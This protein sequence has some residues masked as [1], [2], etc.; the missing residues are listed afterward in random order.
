[1][2]PSRL[3]SRCGFTAVSRLLWFV[4]LPLS[5]LNS[6]REGIIFAFAYHQFSAPSL[7]LD[8]YSVLSKYFC[9]INAWMKI[10]GKKITWFGKIKIFSPREEKVILIFSLPDNFM[11][12]LSNRLYFFNKQRFTFIPWTG[13]KVCN[14]GIQAELTSQNMQTESEKFSHYFWEKENEQYLFRNLL[15]WWSANSSRLNPSNMW[16]RTYLYGSFV[17]EE[18]RNKQEMVVI[19][20]YVFWSLSSILCLPPFLTS[21]SSAESKPNTSSQGQT[22]LPVPCLSPYLCWI[23]M[24]KCVSCPCISL[25]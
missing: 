12:N 24:Y 13:H 15:Y 2:L 19:F 23:L 25:T 1:M 14:S 3:V 22:N 11:N 16:T 7:V 6:E 4:Y 21:L 18:E 10:S 5:A 17:K 20:R 8:T 9:L